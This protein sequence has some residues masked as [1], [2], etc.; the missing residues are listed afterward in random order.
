MNFFAT[1]FWWFTNFVFS[2][3]LLFSRVN[4]LI[5]DTESTDYNSLA[6]IFPPL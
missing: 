5:F 6:E 1:F 4:I 2:C 3:H